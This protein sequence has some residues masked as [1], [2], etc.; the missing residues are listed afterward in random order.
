LT[1]GNISL[2][3][4]GAGSLGDD[5]ISSFFGLFHDDFSFASLFQATE[6][7]GVERLNSFQVGWGNDWFSILYGGGIFADGWSFTDTGVA[8]VNGTTGGDSSVPEPATLVIIGL[9]LAG[10]GLARRRRK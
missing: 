8:W 5:W 1:Y 9:G 7:T 3:L 10:L 4:S 6:V 2:D